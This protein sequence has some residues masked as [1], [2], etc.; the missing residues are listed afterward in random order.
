MGQ[1]DT[2]RSKLKP[3]CLDG[4]K[5]GIPV[6]GNLAKLTQTFAGS[7]KLVVAVDHWSTAGVGVARGLEAG[8]TQHV[9]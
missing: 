1:D 4:I 5:S 8:G 9:G 2:R 6:N 3:R 7:S